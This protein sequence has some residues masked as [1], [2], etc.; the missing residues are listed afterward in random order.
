M[1]SDVLYIWL[2]KIA[3]TFAVVFT[4]ILG[5][6]I[7]L[8][9]LIKGDFDRLITKEEMKDNFITHEKEFA[10]LVAYFDSLSPKDKG[11]TVW[12]ELKDTECINFF[13]SNKVTLVVTGYSANVIGGEN[14][15]LT[16]PEMDSVLKELKWT[17]ETVAALSLKLKKTKCDLIQTL[18]ETKYPIRIY[19]NQGGF[20]P[21]SY[22]IFDKAIPDSLISE[23]GKP[24][25][26]TTLGKRVVVN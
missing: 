18:D 9:M 23:Y 25:S 20:L 24:I 26:Y 8:H 4:C 7:L 15:E 17:K 12:F 19:P 3:V 5:Y 6:Y 21:H 14:I 2:Y 13:N 10:D 16:S 22:M 11:Q 1:K